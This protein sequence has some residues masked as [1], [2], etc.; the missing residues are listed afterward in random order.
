MWDRLERLFRLSPKARKIL[1]K[2]ARF[3][4]VGD[5]IWVVAS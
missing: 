1:R 2:L 5:R 3:L 4:L